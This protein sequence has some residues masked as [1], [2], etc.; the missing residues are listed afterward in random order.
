M[1]TVFSGGWSWAC[2]A[3]MVGYLRRSKIE[4][5]VFS[6]LGLTVGVAT[7]YLFKNIS[8]VVPAGL[9]AGAV[10]PGEGI[11]QKII[12]WTIGA[13]VLGAPVGL[14]GNLAR[15][16]EWGGLPFRLIVPL[17]AFYETSMRLEVEAS[18]A[19]PV[20]GMTWGAV[21]FVAGVT[22]LALVGRTIWSWWHGR[23]GVR[24]ARQVVPPRSASNYEHPTE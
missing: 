19:D 15:V 7:Y 23:R 6:S 24:S 22:A 8:P 12:P 1:S 18:T 13:F 21:R 20:T 9:D 3:F 11:L 2:Y 17:I 10:A 4:S 16:P 14:L 5:A